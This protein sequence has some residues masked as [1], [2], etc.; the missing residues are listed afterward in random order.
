MQALGPLNSFLLY[1]PQL[2]GAKS[3]FF[4]FLTSSQLFSNHRGGW[5]HLLD[6]RHCAPFWEPSFLEAWNRWWLFVVQSPSLFQ[7]FT[8]P[9]GLQHTRLPSPLT[10]SQSWPKFVIV[11][12]AMASNH[13]ILCHALLFLPS[14]FPAS[15]SFPMS[16]LFTSGGQSTGAS[17]SDLPMNIQGWFPLRLMVWSPCCYILVYWCGQRYSISQR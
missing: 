8:R 1:A 10:I 7:L 14:I 15:G 12:L 6:C 5:Q 2:S 9:H 16:Q 17:A 13:L 3:C 11:E 4:W